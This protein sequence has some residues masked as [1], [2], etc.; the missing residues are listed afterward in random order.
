MT[1]ELWD[2]GTRNIVAAFATERE[3]LHL[4]REA[5]VRHGEDWLATVTLVCEDDLGEIRTVESGPALLT[6]AA[7]MAA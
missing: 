2:T 5:V 4:V 1:F 6:R 7:A 3:A